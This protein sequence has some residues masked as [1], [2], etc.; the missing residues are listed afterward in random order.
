MIRTERLVLRIPEAR[1]R[2]A[3]VAMLSDPE[4]MRD[5][6][7]AAT[8]E[9]AAWSLDRH[10]T[11][12]EQ[13]GLGFWVVERDG[14]VAGFCGLKPGAPNTPIAA[15]VEIGWIFGRAHWGQGFAVE[16]AR[17]SLDWG[18]ATTKAPRI[19]A[20]TGAGHVRSQA[21]M[22]RLGMVRLE[23]GDFVHPNYP[24]GDPLG[25]SVTFAISR[26]TDSPL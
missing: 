7:P 2:A 20:I 24:A 12:R 18:W 11:Y 13:Q 15:D 1:D 8:Q 9:T 23:Q 19:V 5:L 26:P 25:Q 21:V 17:A 10:A 3:L 22:H 4:T 14:T 16:A 6:N